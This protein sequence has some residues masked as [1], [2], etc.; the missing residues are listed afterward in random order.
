MNTLSNPGHCCIILIIIRHFLACKDNWGTSYC[1]GAKGAGACSAAQNQLQCQKTC[2]NCPGNSILKHLL[3]CEVIFSK[4]NSAF[5]KYISYSVNS[6]PVDCQ[7]NSW[8]G[9]SSCSQ[10]CGGGKITYRRTKKVP[11]SGGGKC[12]GK[13][14]KME[15]CNTKACPPVDCRWVSWQKDGKCSKECGG[16]KQKY[17]RWKMVNEAHG[18]KCEGKST[19]EEDCNTQACP[20]KA[21]N[22]KMNVTNYFNY[23]SRKMFI[24]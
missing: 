4:L 24:K 13:E 2:D 1:E 6:V 12:E 23:F 22:I 10:T 19:K 11:E 9:P 3:G 14:T 18:G 8:G 20:G 7:W 5:F 17:T 15:D 21:R 16:G